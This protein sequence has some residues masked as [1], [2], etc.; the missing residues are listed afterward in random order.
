MFHLKEISLWL[1]KTEIAP[2]ANF[3]YEKSAEFLIYP[4][5]LFF[6][7]FPSILIHFFV[8]CRFGLFPSLL[9]QLR[10]FS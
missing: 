8:E 4:N 1:K 7:Y 2:L 6:I 5:I 3:G 9:Y 10:L